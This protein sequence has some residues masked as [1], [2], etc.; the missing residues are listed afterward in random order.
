[1]GNYNNIQL[2]NQTENQGSISEN[3]SRDYEWDKIYIIWN[4][5]TDN[6]FI[7]KKINV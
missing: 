7:Q 4:N 6:N 2:I 5:T 3:T 1:M